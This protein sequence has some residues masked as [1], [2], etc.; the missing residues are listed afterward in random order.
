M[1][2]LCNILL[3]TLGCFINGVKSTDAILEICENLK[4][5]NL[6]LVEALSVDQQRNLSLVCESLKV[7]LAEANQDINETHATSLITAI[8]P[9]NPEMHTRTLTFKMLQ[10]GVFT[11][12]E[13]MT[14]TIVSLSANK[15]YITVAT[16]QRHNWFNRNIPITLVTYRSSS[17]NYNE[18]TLQEMRV[19][20][21]NNFG[22]ENITPIPYGKDCSVE[23]TIPSS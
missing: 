8:R 3:V 2:K 17:A 1:W 22:Y 5:E 11:E 9:G 14:G 10:L 6:T 7:S 19:K 20:N 16:C 23:Q 18:T 15:D 12:A 4:P 21:Q 13:G